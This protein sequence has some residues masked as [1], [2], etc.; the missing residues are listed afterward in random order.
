MPVPVRVPPPPGQGHCDSHRRPR[1]PP[2]PRVMARGPMRTPNGA[3]TGA[4]FDNGRPA[5]K[6]LCRRFWSPLYRQPARKPLDNMRPRSAAI[7]VE[8]LMIF[9]LDQ[10][11]PAGRSLPVFVVDYELDYCADVPVNIGCMFFLQFNF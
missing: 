8:E 1:T 4:V 3:T 5:G 11:Q 6:V 10:R 9:T 7:I 2:A